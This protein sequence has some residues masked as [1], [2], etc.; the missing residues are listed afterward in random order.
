MTTATAMPG[1]SLAQAQAGENV[2]DLGGVMERTLCL[3]LTLGRY[4]T[5]RR[6]DSELVQT[7]ADKKLVRVTKRI[8]RHPLV[9][10]IR[11][12]DG[13]TREWVVEHSVPSFFRGGLYLVAFEGVEEVDDYLAERDVERTALVTALIDAYAA[14]GGLIETDRE[15][16]GDIFDEAEYP[17]PAVVRAA[18]VFDTRWLTFATPKKLKAIS[19]AIFQREVEKQERAIAAV[20]EQVQAL[21]RAE[22]KDLVD[23]MADRLEVDGKTGKPKVFRSTLVSNLGEFL[24]TVKLRNVTGDSELEQVSERLRKL[25]EG[26]TVET[27]R[28]EGALRDHVRAR[29]DEIKAALATMVTDRPTRLM[30]LE[31]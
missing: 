29:M 26:V 11:K 18:Y 30:E 12:H 2:Q 10:A 9:D 21:L 19:A 27:L 22:L 4:G 23:H 31:E 20:G 13:G 7:D 25:L 6:V 1:G 3:S 17:K 8:L 15:Q 24:D 16:L 28:E 5:S 14:P